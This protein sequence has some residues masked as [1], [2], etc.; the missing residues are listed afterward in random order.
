MIGNWGFILGSAVIVLS[1]AWKVYRIGIY[2][3]S[4]LSINASHPFGEMKKVRLMRRI[5]H[6]PSF[7]LPTG[8]WIHGSVFFSLLIF[9]SL[10]N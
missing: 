2:F 8:A 1:Q 6:Q 3:S 9:G 10:F 7:V 5:H 4:F